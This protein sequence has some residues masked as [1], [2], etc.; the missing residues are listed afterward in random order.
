MS[1][2]G[3]ILNSLKDLVDEKFSEFCH[4][5]T[6]SRVEPRIRASE[7]DGKSRVKITELLV[8][9]W[10]EAT[11]LDKTINILKEIG[12]HNEAMELAAIAAALPK[13]KEEPSRTSPPQGSSAAGPS[14]A[15]ARQGHFVDRHRNDLI[16]NV[17]NMNPI[18]DHLFQE[19]VLQPEQYD[20]VMEIKTTQNQMRF[21]FRGPL[22]SG[23]RSKNVLMDA[24]KKNQPY[25]IKELE[26][27]EG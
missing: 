26:E 25:L 13:P 6:A 2:S 18:L 4:K 24:L 23:D 22:K 8:S 19:G 17:S 5:V 27:K 3:H 20:E 1:V 9:R 16:D 10:T 12:C 7:V 11:A 14:G 15:P 21:L